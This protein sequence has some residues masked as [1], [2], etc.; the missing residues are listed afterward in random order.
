MPNN[1]DHCTLT[2][3]IDRPHRRHSN[4]ITFNRPVITLHLA[5]A[6]RTIRRGLHMRHTCNTNELFEVARDKLRAIVGNDSWLRVGIFLSRSLKNGFE[7]DLFH[8]LADFP[9]YNGTTTAVQ[10]AA[11]EIKRTA[12][13]QVTDIDMPM[14]V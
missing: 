1:P 4:A 5:I 11:H 7:I 8:F 2:G 3:I 10:D 14:L 6:L 9:V 12:D 13:V